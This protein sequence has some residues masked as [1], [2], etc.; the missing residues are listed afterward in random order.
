MARK[1]N[2]IVLTPLDDGNQ[3]NAIRSNA[4]IVCFTGGTGGGKSVALYYAPIAHLAMNDNAKIVCFM[5]NVSDFW[6]AGKV[7]DTLKKM[8]PL[9]D[10]S[11]KK[12]P[13]DPIGEIIRNQTDMGMKL[14]NGSEIKFQQLDN[15]NPVVIDK[16][17]KGLQ[18]KKLIFDECNKFQ[19]RT[20]TS[21]FPRLRSDASGKAQIY[22]AQN[23][24][25]ECFLRKLCGKGE[26]GGGWINNDG[27]IDKDMDGVVMFFNMQDGDIDK[28]YWG[29]TK[30]EVYEKCKEHIDSLIAQDPD[31][32]YEDFILSMV[33]FTFDVRDN[34]K[35]LSKNKSYRGLAANSST[36]A[37]SYSVNWNYSLE[38]EKCSIEDIANIQLHTIDIER[39]FRPI[40]MAF[41]SECVKRFMTVDMAT[42]GFDNLVMM[43]WELWSHYGFI[44][45][46]IKYSINNTN[47]EAVM[48]MV[49]FR[50][51]HELSEREMIIDIQGFGFL[52]DCFP[53]AINF[54]GATQPTER[55]KAQ[56]KTRKDESAHLAM[57][58]IQNGL[59]HFEPRLAEMR[60][61]HKNMKREGGTTILKHLKFESVIFQ[62]GKTPNGRITF[63]DKDKQHTILKG[64][65][66]DLFD[67]IIMLCGGVYH[68]CYNLL[69]DDAG[70]M[71]KK[72]QADDMLAMLSIN[73][74]EPTSEI[75]G[76]T[77]I[78]KKRIR[79]ASEILNILSTI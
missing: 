16:I 67:N 75:I 68:T 57:E 22:L 74:D 30:L 65:S 11:V 9:I 79:N 36:A 51:K 54:S 18:A 78:K 3:K 76:T 32:T 19:W 25:R 29:R 77:R 53:R 24:E 40:D 37:S 34:K 59:M 20:I 39:M 49:D 6:G 48:M 72:M 56:Y 71:K 7:N 73:G 21:F 8:Y 26:H 66:P 27:T 31:M 50:E 17:A 35:M 63:L 15:E 60:Y 70:V 45:K 46:D 14:Y 69:R 38:D 52:Q 33:F 64:M 42:T 10:R 41:N 44:C 1:R 23:P 55:S 5:R 61:T 62:F 13:H 47:R 12:Q 43:Y 58:I 28:T 4:D 2:D